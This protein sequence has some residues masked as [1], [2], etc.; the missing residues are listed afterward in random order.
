MGTLAPT[1]APQVTA[2]AWISQ[3]LTS[4]LAAIRF[5]AMMPSKPPP[6]QGQS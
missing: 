6:D 1:T 2:W 3:L 4:V 5:W